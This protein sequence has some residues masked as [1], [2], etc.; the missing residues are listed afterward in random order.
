MLR[1]ENQLLRD[2]IGELDCGGAGGAGGAGAGR[3]LEEEVRRLG[4]RTAELEAELGAA[5]AESLALLALAPAQLADAA[6]DKLQRM[7]VHVHKT[8]ERDH[9]EIDTYWSKVTTAS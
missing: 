1:R 7:R 9:S 4:A 3:A 8:A 5:R 6:G 2:K